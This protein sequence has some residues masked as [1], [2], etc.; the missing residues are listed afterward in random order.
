MQRTQKYHRLAVWIVTDGKN[1]WFAALEERP[2]AVFAGRF[3]RQ[4]LNDKE[5]VHVERRTA[6]LSA[7]P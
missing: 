7:N 2:A 5:Q 4:V 1:D 6:T 3:N